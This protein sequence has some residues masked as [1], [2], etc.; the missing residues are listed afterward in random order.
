MH[1]ACDTFNVTLFRELAVLKF[2][3]DFTEGNKNLKDLL[4]GKGQPRRDDESRPSRAARTL[5]DPADPLLAS[6]RSG[7]KFSMPGVMDTVGWRTWAPSAARRQR[8]PVVTG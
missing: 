8:R 7:S 5:C 6:V 1:R 3:Y 4:G 2:V